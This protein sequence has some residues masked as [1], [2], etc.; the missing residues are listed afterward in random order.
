M[1]FFSGT[2]SN[3]RHTVNANELL[4]NLPSQKK[5]V[6]YGNNNHQGNSDFN[7]QSFENKNWRIIKYIIHTIQLPAK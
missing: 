4:I 6:A 2:Q 7:V 5:M 3:H 1:I